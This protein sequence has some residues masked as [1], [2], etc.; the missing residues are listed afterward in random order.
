MIGYI[1]YDLLNKTFRNNTLDTEDI[2]IIETLYKGSNMLNY[3]VTLMVTYY[4]F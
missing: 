4:R 1:V 3:K 2:P